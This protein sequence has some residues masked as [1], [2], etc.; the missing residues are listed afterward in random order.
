[1]CVRAQA[2]LSLKLRYHTC[3]LEDGLF[4][5]INGNFSSEVGRGACLAS[6]CNYFLDFLPKRLSRLAVIVLCA[7]DKI[8]IFLER[9]V[10]NVEAGCES[11]FLFVALRWRGGGTLNN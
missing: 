8:L 9:G 11:A 1:M 2:C 4:G 5:K 6:R 7:K 10:K 3:S